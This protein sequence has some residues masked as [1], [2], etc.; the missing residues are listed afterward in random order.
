MVYALL[1]VLLV[2]ADQLTKLLAYATGVSHI[3]I[4]PGFLEIDKMQNPATGD[5]NTG[6]SFGW[7]ED[8]AWALP[9]FIAVT[10][11]ALIIFL[12]A[13]LKMPAKKRFLRLSLVFIMAGAAG[14]LIDRVVLGGVRDFIYMDFSFVGISPFWNNV[15]DLVITAGAVMF[16]LALL[17]VDDDALFRLGKKKEREELEKAASALPEQPAAIDSDAGEGARHQKE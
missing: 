12:I 3:V 15:A 10:V 1:F 5:L 2:F 17:F 11:V 13:F 4:I 9:M 14:N 8:K 6:M 16:V 7:L